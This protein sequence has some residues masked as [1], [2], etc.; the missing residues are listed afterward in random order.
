MILR[1]SIGIFVLVLIGVY[2]GCLILL[3][4]NILV[5]VIVLNL[6]LDSYRIGIFPVLLAFVFKILFM[7]IIFCFSFLTGNITVLI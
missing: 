4:R 7:I 6:S 5:Q 3:F 2:V 1:M